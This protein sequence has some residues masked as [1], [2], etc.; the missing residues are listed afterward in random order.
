MGLCG[1]LAEFPPQWDRILQRFFQQ[2]RGPLSLERYSKE[3]SEIHLDLCLEEL[4]AWYS[5]YYP[6]MP[7]ALDP[8]LG[9]VESEQYLFYYNREGRVVAFKMQG[10][11]IMAEYD[12][13]AIV[14]TTPTVFEIKLAQYRGSRSLK[15]DGL[16]GGNKRGLRVH[17]HPEVY[18]KKLIPLQEFFG[19]DVGYVFIIPRDIY[20]N[21]NGFS[22]S[23]FSEFQHNGGIVVPFYTDRMS[24]R[25]EVASIVAEEGIPF[26]PQRNL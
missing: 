26:N 1:R 7:I 25:E 12:K 4:Q 19:T 5:E 3:F 21:R 8:I 13:V 24:F 22:L 6:Q 11:N 17:L 23:L 2:D 18:Q 10:R 15:T 9:G 14:N 20:E 16:L